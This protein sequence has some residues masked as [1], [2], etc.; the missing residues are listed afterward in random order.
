ME[1]WSANHGIDGSKR[2]PQLAV[3][4]MPDGTTERQ[5]YSVALEHGRQ[6]NIGRLDIQSPTLVVWQYIA[7]SVLTSKDSSFEHCTQSP[8]VEIR[9]AGKNQSWSRLEQLSTLDAG[10]YDIRVAAAQEPVPL[11]THFE[12]RIRETWVTT[13]NPADQ[14]V[15][16][17]FT[18]P[19]ERRF[20]IK[21]DYQGDFE[22]RVRFLPDML[23]RWTYIWEHS[24]AGER[25]EGMTNAFD[26][27]AWD[28]NTVMAGL[29]S[30]SDSI[31]QSGA[32]PRSQAM[33]P[34]EIAFMKLERAAM[35]LPDAETGQPSEKLAELNRIIR[36]LRH[37]LSGSTIPRE[38]QPESI[39]MERAKAN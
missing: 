27:V 3:H 34:Y 5:Q 11:G 22:W 12:S 31:D 16:W 36:E 37:Q 15:K 2:R 17:I 14:D 8:H 18:S 25:A 20:V 29:K 35:V 23:G 38:F 24:L 10:L 33:L 13:G 28:F 19:D 26:V 21:A 9:A 4:W 7:S 30:L 39:R 6:M 1:I 32:K